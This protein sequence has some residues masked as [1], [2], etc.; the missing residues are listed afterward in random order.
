MN[1]MRVKKS[2]GS[3]QLPSPSPTHLPSPCRAARCP[4][5]TRRL[6]SQARRMAGGCR[7][8]VSGCC[9][10]AEVKGSGL[11]YDVPLCACMRALMQ[12]IHKF[13]PYLSERNLHDDR[14]TEAVRGIV[15]CA[16]MRG[17]EARAQCT[18]RFFSNE[19]LAH[20][21]RR[22]HP[23]PRRT[24]RRLHPAE[25]SRAAMPSLMLCHKITR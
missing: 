19:P 13:M 1:S 6:S 9:L 21:I 24:N 2:Q 14:G 4:C 10:P 18:A 17:S 11:R 25:V 15:S 5:Q 7:P 16:C 22:S 23:A 8:G 20:Q 12:I 3:Q